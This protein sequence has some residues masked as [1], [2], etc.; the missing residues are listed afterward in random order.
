MAPSSAL[1]RDLWLCK[2]SA[3][4]CI[5]TV[6]WTGLMFSMTWRIILKLPLAQTAPRTFQM[7]QEDQ[8]DKNGGCLSVMASYMSFQKVLSSLLFA[9]V[10]KVICGLGWFLLLQWLPL[11][12]HVEFTIVVLT[13]KTVHTK[14]YWTFGAK[15][16]RRSLL[17]ASQSLTGSGVSFRSPVKVFLV[18]Y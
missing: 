17:P 10:K 12:L 2:R 7:A 9:I 8:T 18:T 5:H 4:A 15:I 11:Q 6:P 3:R 14:V 13:V 16:Y 1:N